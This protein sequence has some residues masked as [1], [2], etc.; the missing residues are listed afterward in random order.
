MSIRNIKTRLGKVEKLTGIGRKVQIIQPIIRYSHT[1][2]DGTVPNVIDRPIEEWELYKQ[3]F[4]QHSDGLPGP[5]IRIDPLEEYRLRTGRDEAPP[6]DRIPFSVY[7]D[8]PGKV[9]K[10]NKR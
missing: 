10:D 6:A 8:W 9:T 2:G 5:V 7:Q 4:S 3:A 1:Y